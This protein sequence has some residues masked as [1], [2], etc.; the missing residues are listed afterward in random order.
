MVFISC[1]ENASKWRG[2]GLKR[3]SVNLSNVPKKWDEG[4][5]LKRGLLLGRLQYLLLLQG[6]M[7]DIST[8]NNLAMMCFCLL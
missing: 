4:L 8:P 7:V 1:N 2:G 5:L 6:Y 3:A